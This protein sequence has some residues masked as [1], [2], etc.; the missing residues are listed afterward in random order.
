VRV[1]YDTQERTVKDSGLWVSELARTHRIPEGPD[2][3]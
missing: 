3:L 1:D 2:A